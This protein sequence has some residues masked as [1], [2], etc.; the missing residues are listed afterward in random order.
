MAGFNQLDKLMYQNYKF[1]KEDHVAWAFICY[2]SGKENLHRIKNELP[3]GQFY[4][5]VRTVST[6]LDIS[7]KKAFKLIDEFEKAGILSKIYTA[8]SRHEA[9]IFRY[10]II[11]ETVE[12]T[13]TVN[14]TVNETIERSDTNSLN[15]IVETVK[16]TIKETPK[17][18][19]IKRTLNNS[20][21]DFQKIEDIYKQHCSDL[22]QI[23]ELSEPRKRTLKAWG[24]IEEIEEVFIKAGKSSFLSGK[25]PP[26]IPGGRPFKA[27]FDWIIKP[28]NRVKILEGNYDDQE[29][30]NQ[31]EPIEFLRYRED[32]DG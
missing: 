8:R 17:K 3:E 5:T 22:T 31:R 12:N 4:M 24:S 1:R 7:I 27:T 23:R 19:H 30:P 32:Q 10:N 26:K 9:S 16:E 25:V 6:D 2:I 18:E 14:E 20:G 28:A 15:D 29:V 11:V 21:L 13:E